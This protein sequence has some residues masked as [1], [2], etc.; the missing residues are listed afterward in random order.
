M[1]RQIHFL[2][3]L[4]FLISTT[5]T[6][7]SASQEE[8]ADDIGDEPFMRE[9]ESFQ[10]V[11]HESN[12]GND[13]DRA[14]KKAKYVRPTVSGGDHFLIE[15]FDA[16]LI[17]SKWV[18]SRAKKEDVDEVI[19]KYD[20][21]WTIEPSMD[22]VLEGDRG[23]VLKSKAKHHAI[24]AR[25][26]KPFDFKNNRALVLQYE[27]KFQNPMECGGAY[28]KLI[29][30]EP[31]F[32]LENFYDK[33]GF[34]IMFG[35]DKCGPDNKFHLIIR[36]KH[37]KTGAYEEKHAK[38]SELPE[39]LF[40][41]TKTH[42][43]TLIMRDDNTYT[44]LIDQREVNS[45]H[46]LRDLTPP[47]N[48]PAE[49]VD[50]NDKKPETW[51]DRERIPDPDAVK[52]DDWDESEPKQIVDPAATMPSG[53]LE[54]EPTHVPDESAK[55]PDDW[56]NETD[57]EWEAPKVDNPKCKHAAGCGKWKAPMI[58]NPKYKGIW[59]APMIENTNYQGKWQPRKIPN[60][61]FFEDKN[62][63]ASL[64]RFSGVGLELWSMTDQIYF[65]NFIISDDESVA[66]QLASET[67]QLKNE[68]ETSNAKS[69][70]SVITSLVNAT[71][72]KPWLWA[73]YL[74]VVL[75][76]VVLIVVFCCS[77]SKKQQQQQEESE[78]SSAARKKKTDEP[79]KDDEDGGAD[80]EEN[81]QNGEEEED[82][83]QEE[84]E[85][86]TN[87]MRKGDLEAKSGNGNQ[88]GE[89]EV[90]EDIEVI[91]KPSSKPASPKQQ[92]TAASKRKPRK[93]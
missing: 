26:S 11:S 1:R 80:E 83:N 40:T 70:D 31:S 30:D 53:W 66:R 34:T 50:P 90:D 47:I 7:I 42:L 51:D 54:D 9:D 91:E 58:D 39:G 79:T 88:S 15:T 21:E 93:D 65:D 69:A 64:T 22:A 45:G 28:I 43:F 33:T 84:E 10:D 2:V 72:D 73:V 24:S 62:P 46:L 25:L 19:A 55:K 71:N 27:V 6:F 63:F 8:E 41:D 18:K 57:G 56:D 32:T 23:L 92:S 14:I 74:L 29:S 86:A 81:Q 68:L 59:R 61:D 85:E 35:P 48:P 17:G 75:L 76:P 87:K 13:N 44:I 67:W 16:D 60:P 37:P 12:N 49:I 38:K 82:N 4:L 3:F 52:P 89:E 78:S 36:H 77:G 20:G 5:T